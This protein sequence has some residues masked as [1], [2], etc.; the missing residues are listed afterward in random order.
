MRLRPSKP[1]PLSDFS[2]GVPQGAYF[3]REWGAFPA[4]CPSPISPP[5]YPRER[6]P[7]ESGAPAFRAPERRAPLPSG[8]PL[9]GTPAVIV[10][11]AR[12]RGSCS[13]AA[14]SRSNP[15]N[16]GYEKS[17]RRGRDSNP[18]YSFTRTTA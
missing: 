9:Q 11:A 14:C 7:S 8:I 3:I 15:R 13:S 10:A 6:I 2:T 1:L 12:V 5:G 17:W 16:S 4:A 18:R